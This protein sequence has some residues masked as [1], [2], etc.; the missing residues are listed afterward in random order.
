MYAQGKMPESIVTTETHRRQHTITLGTREIRQALIDHGL[1]L[2]GFDQAR[3]AGFSGIDLFI[4]G[5]DERCPATGELRPTATI[6]FREELSTPTDFAPPNIKEIVRLNPPA[7]PGL[8]QRQ[9]DNAL[10][11]GMKWQGPSGNPLSED[12]ASAAALAK[13]RTLKEPTTFEVSSPL[14][15]TAASSRENVDAI[16]RMKEEQPALLKAMDINARYTER[17][18]GITRDLWMEDLMKRVNRL[19]EVLLHG[20]GHNIVL[21]KGEVDTLLEYI[22]VGALAVD[23]V[24][25][26][27]YA[28]PPYTTP[29][30]LPLP[31][32]ASVLS[33]ARGV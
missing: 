18:T 12:L 11:V 15:T 9:I 13:S 30:N 32:G 19:H 20:K 22:D 10:W 1:R 33:A 25:Q 2:L 5:P 4:D 31:E 28:V 3:P 8:S 21:T 6:T 7:T 16:E 14:N 17:K 29:M 23:K 24:Q 27:G 26:A